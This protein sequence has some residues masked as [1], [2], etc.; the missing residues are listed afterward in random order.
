MERTRWGRERGLAWTAA[1]LFL[2]ATACSDGRPAG[3]D[4]VE[5]SAEEAA[6]LATETDAAVGLALGLAMDNQEAEVAGSGAPAGLSLSVEPITRTFRFERSVTCSVGG[7][8]TVSGQGAIV[9]DR[10]ARS[11]EVNAAGSKV[12]SNCLRRRGEHVLGVDGGV[13]FSGHRKKVEGEIVELV[14][15][16]EGRW[17][18]FVEGTDREKSC[19]VD[20]HAELEGDIVHITGTFCGREVDRT[21]DVG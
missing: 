21:R 13:E 17:T 8:W 6:F 18:V 7:S 16:I 5:L 12:A 10:E 3:P 4:D 11:V 15:D 2:G 20:L 19:Q 14:H 1:L 9:V